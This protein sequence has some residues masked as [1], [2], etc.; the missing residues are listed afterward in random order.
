M[1]KPRDKYNAKIAERTMQHNEIKKG[2]LTWKLGSFSSNGTRW[3]EASRH[4]LLLKKSP[5]T[6]EADNACL[7]QEQEDSGQKVREW[8]EYQQGA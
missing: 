3:T 6:R 5:Q 1:D 2:Q 4:I 7:Q 8:L